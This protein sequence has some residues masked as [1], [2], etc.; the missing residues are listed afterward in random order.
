MVRFLFLCS[1]FPSSLYP[2]LFTCHRLFLSYYILLIL[3]VRGAFSIV[4]EGTNRETGEKVAI[5]QIAKQHI[6]A[7]GI[8]PSPLFFG[9]FPLYL[10]FTYQDM[11]RLSTEIEIMKK[12]KHNNIIQ[13]IEVFDNSADNLY[14]VMELYVISFSAILPLL[15]TFY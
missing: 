12:L 13:L 5:K 4:R 9:S 14:L 7:A 15:F 10:C 8:P 2:P 6:T 3:F 11:K 1:P